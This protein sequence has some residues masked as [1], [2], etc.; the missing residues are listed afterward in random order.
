MAFKVDDYVVLRAGSDAQVYTID[1]LDGY[2]VKLAYKRGD[3]LAYTETDV[4]RLMKPSKEQMKNF[5]L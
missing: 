4:C 1:E 3:Q 5:L 2:Y